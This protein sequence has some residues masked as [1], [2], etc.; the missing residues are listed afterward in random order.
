MTNEQDNID[1]EKRN[2]L[3]TMGGLATVGV[4]A[5]WLPTEKVGAGFFNSSIRK[6]LIGFPSDVEIYKQKYENWSGESRLDNAWTA[7]PKNQQKVLD[8]INWAAKNGYKVRAKG[9]SHNWSPILLDDSHDAS[10]ILLIDMA[11]YLTGVT[12]SSQ[13]IVS[14]EAGIQME[15]LLAKIEEH[16]RGLLAAPAPGDITLGGVLAIGGHGTGVPAQDELKKSGETYGSISNLVFSI[17]AVVYDTVLNEY[18]AKKFYRYEEEISALLVNLGRA[19]ILSAQLQTSENTFLRCESIVDVHHLELFSPDKNSGRTFSYYLDQSGRVEAIWFPFTDNPWIKVWTVTNKRPIS[20]KHVNR[21]FNYWFSDNVIKPITDTIHEIIV[22]NN[23]SLTRGFGQLQF[24]IVKLGLKGTVLSSISTIVTGGIAS[25][26]TDDLWGSSKNLLLYVKPTTL[27]VT[28]NGYAVITRRDNV[29]TVIADFCEFYSRKLK[30]Y[31]KMNRFPMNGPVE[32]RVTGLDHPVD[33]IVPNAQVAGLSAIKP[34]PDHPEWDCAVWFDILTLPGTPFSAQ[35]YTEVEFWMSSR[36]Q[37][38]S[39]MR[40]EWSKGWGY[41]NDKAWNSSTYIDYEIPLV[42]G[43]GQP[44]RLTIRSLS[45]I[46]K[47]HDP[48]ALFTAPLSTRILK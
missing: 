42:H 11:T 38:D 28:A 30:E 35:F 4:V 24:E 36:Y 18:V 20:S 40:P 17:T 13:G 48:L 8:V 1:L 6:Q 3:K 2:F 5:T 26:Q 19:F 27:R 22:K 7:I 21:P 29:Q 34:C 45:Q 32:I 23:A 33:S 15:A 9:K 12:V 44:D 14:A 10:N 25:S 41:T 47:K 46:F 43:Q 16:G 39:L 37:G 31:E